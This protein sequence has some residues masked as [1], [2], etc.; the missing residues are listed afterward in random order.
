MVTVLIGFLI[1]PA[2]ANELLLA[3]DGRSAAVIVSDAQDGT[4]E[5]YAAREL[6][7]GIQLATGAMLPIR[8]EVPG[9]HH[10]VIIVGTPQSQP[11]IARLCPELLDAPAMRDQIILRRSQRALL[12]AGSNP[13][14]VLYA[15]CDFLEQQL[16]F[17]WLWPGEEGEFYASVPRL[18]IGV[19]DRTQT[20]AIPY[21][22]LSINAPHY[23]DLTLEWMARNRMNN[24]WSDHYFKPEWNANLR[25][26][27]MINVLG[28]HNLY[29]PKELLLEHPEYTAEFGGERVGYVLGNPHLCWSNPEVQEALVERLG[30]WIET[31]PQIDLW[32][33]YPADS[34]KFCQCAG[35]ME[36]APDLSTRYQKL[37]TLLIG[38]LR[39]RYPDHDL[40]FSTLAYQDYRDVPKG[41][42]APMAVNQYATYN[43]SYK[44]PLGSGHPSN[45]KAIEEFFQWLKAGAAM[46]IRGYEMI[47]FR[48]AMFV[49]LVYHVLDTMVFMKKHGMIAY[50]TEVAPMGYDFT[51]KREGQPEGQGWATNRLNLYAVARGMWNPEVTPQEV[52]REW[53]SAIYG[54]AAGPM[55]DYYFLMEEA[56][57]SSPGNISYFFNSPA[58]YTRGFVT[59]S[60]VGKANALFG[61]ARKRLHDLP[62]EQQRQR[63]LQQVAFEEKLFRNWEEL[64]QYL[65][66]Q[67][68]HFST[69][70]Y[71]TSATGEELFD[72]AAQA[73]TKAAV[74][75]PFHLNGKPIE[76]PTQV[77]LLWNAESLFLKVVCAEVDPTR[78]VT[79]FREDHPSV[80]EDDSLEFFLKSAKDE[81]YAHL[82]VNSLGFR[83]S[84][85]FSGAMSSQAW[86][87]NWRAR[88]FEVKGG[89]GVLLSLPLAELGIE[90]KPGVAIP[91]SIKRT[92]PGR[93]PSGWPDEVYHSPGSHGMIRLVGGQRRRVALYGGEG[94]RNEALE[95]EFLKA[96]WE[97]QWIGQ[98]GGVDLSALASFDAVFLRYRSGKLYRFAEEFVREALVP[99]VEGGGLL[100]ISSINP[101]FLSNWFGDDFALDWT[102]WEVH[103]QRRTLDLKEGNWLREPEDLRSAFR[104]AVTPASGVMPQSD[105]WEVLASL[106]LS[107]RRPAPFLVRCAVQEGEL[108]VT[109]S[110]MGYGGGGEIFGDSNP[111]N[112]VKLLINLFEDARSRRQKH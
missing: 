65:Q 72:P 80:Y 108:V 46:G 53:T 4:V 110:D 51:G 76:E 74:L 61:A 89:W 73:W 19:L 12:I 43:V 21:R 45:Q 75:P 16:G 106:P 28:G 34:P 82:V 26:K 58:A 44:H 50:S 27:G 5:A 101:T 52:V 15:V 64:A 97:V 104:E 37:C 91:M 48:D 62:G 71:Q 8:R 83:S 81:S 13:R 18:A 3:A 94:V 56:W 39:E 87:G 33:M 1:V 55:A 107:D 47:P 49:P 109:T 25:E 102:G 36:M 20:G 98:Q 84:A 90:R 79:R 30:R 92:R 96:G 77:S 10:P 11:E 54:P 2:S 38:A 57:K 23:D 99:Y 100:V 32:G 14:S 111:Q 68:A 9:A 42:L 40:E 95:V 88:P 31:M 78:R 22:S 29:L 7:R 69:V 85:L 67:E 112:V 63:A 86:E 103:P 41:K 35:C 24:H 17:R 105:F 60:L 59:P 66:G 93:P 6:Q 70:A